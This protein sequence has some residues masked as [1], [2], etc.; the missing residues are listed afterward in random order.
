MSSHVM[1]RY[2]LAPSGDVSQVL[3]QLPIPKE[4]EL[5]EVE[6]E[7]QDQMWEAPQ[8]VR[9]LTNAFLLSAA[10]LMLFGVYQRFASGML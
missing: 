2:R 10:A 4:V 1:F 9:W 6:Q 8:A 3:Q 5:K 7:K